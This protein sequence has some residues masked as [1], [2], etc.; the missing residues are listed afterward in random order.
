MLLLLLPAP[1][2]YSYRSSATFTIFCTR[3]AGI[4]ETQEA[5]RQEE[6]VIKNKEPSVRQYECEVKC[7]EYERA[8]G[9]VVV[10]KTYRAF[11]RFELNNIAQCPSEL[12][13]HR[14]EQN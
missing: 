11:R 5:I 4:G 7:E 3:D 13:Y 8:M 2:S 14:H 10:K 1:Y 12:Q 9:V 6:V